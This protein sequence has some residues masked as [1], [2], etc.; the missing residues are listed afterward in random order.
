MRPQERLLSTNLGR[1][2]PLSSVVG[3]HIDYPCSPHNSPPTLRQ[4]LLN[5]SGLCPE[6]YER[7]RVCQHMLV[8]QTLGKRRPTCKKGG[9]WCL[10][11]G[12]RLLAF[13]C[14]HTH[15]HIHAHPCIYTCMCMLRQD[16]PIHLTIHEPIHAHV[17]IQLDNTRRLLSSFSSNVSNLAL[18][19]SR[20]A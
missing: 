16:C 18:G 13:I 4:V 3:P 12:S 8:I 15:L 11:N 2:V 1:K 17:H 10:K 20:F 19:T 9:R 6:R 7:G 14:M 5:S